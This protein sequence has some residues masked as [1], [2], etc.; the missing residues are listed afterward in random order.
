VSSL[1]APSSAA[2]PQYVFWGLQLHPAECGG[3]PGKTAL[4]D[5]AVLF[6]TKLR[7]GHLL[8]LLPVNRCPTDPPL[9]VTAEEDI[10]RLSLIAETAHL[11]P[12]APSRFGLHHAKALEDLLTGRR[13]A[14]DVKRRGRWRPDSSLRRYG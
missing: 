10:R 11:E 7:L 1:V 2:G 14:L 6:N 4:F 9:R 5:E 13:A 12:L 8:Y 3:L